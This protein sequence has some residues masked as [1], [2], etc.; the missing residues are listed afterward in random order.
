MLYHLFNWLEREYDFLGASLFQ[1]ITFRAALS[2]ILSLLITLVFG[3][4]IIA[5]IK[6]KQIL[7]KQRTLGLTGEELKRKTPTM[8]G[9]MIHIAILTPCLLLAD[10]TNVYIQLL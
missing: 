9:L 8:G 10:L 6:N 3:T 7:E 1:Y 5:Y 2:I 4:R